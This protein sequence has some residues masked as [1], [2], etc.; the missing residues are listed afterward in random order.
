[1]GSKANIR[2]SDAPSV[3]ITWEIISF[4]GE[5]AGRDQYIFSAIS[6]KAKRAHIHKTHKAIAI[7]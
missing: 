5:T 7:E 1:M 3:L 2:S 4:L 6:Q